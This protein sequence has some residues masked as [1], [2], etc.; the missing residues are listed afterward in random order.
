MTSLVIDLTLACLT[1]SLAA[2][3]GHSRRVWF[4]IGL[5]GG[6]WVFCGALILL[7]SQSSTP[8]KGGSST[9]KSSP[10][11]PHAA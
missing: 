6:L 1:A 3:R 4:A 10:A 5:L 7:R 11:P 9:S 2:K 8:L